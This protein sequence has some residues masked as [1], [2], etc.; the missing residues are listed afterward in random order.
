MFIVGLSI[1]SNYG[2]EWEVIAIVINLSQNLF[3][4]KIIRVFISYPI[5]GYGEKSLRFPFSWQAKGNPNIY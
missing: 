2:W 1:F 4:L 5:F 3:Y